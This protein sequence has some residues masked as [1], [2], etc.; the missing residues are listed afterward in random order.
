MRAR[1]GAVRAAIALTLMAALGFEFVRTAHLLGVSP[2][3]HLVDYTSYFTTMSNSLAAVT[4]GIGSVIAVRSDSD[5]EWYGQLVI[6]AVAY[7]MTTCTVY[8]ISLR[9]VSTAPD[10]WANE[11]LHVVGPL[12]IAL[13]W[14]VGQHRRVVPWR[15]IRNIMGVPVAWLGY[16]M[17]RGEAVGWYPYDFLDPAQSGGLVSV[18]GCVS[19]AT[20]L[21]IA[22]ALSAIAASRMRASRS[23]TVHRKGGEKLIGTRCALSAEHLATAG[24]VNQQRRRRVDA[25]GLSLRFVRNDI[26]LGRGHPRNEALNIGHGPPSRRAGRTKRRGI[27]HDLHAGLNVRRGARVPVRPLSR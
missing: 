10:S 20:A 23:V 6:A 1:E 19:V 24:R 8:N 17:L 4:F 16:T 22:F 21:I 14:V 5:P 26:P 18:A 9:A 7:T 25:V 11:V 2:L 15:S 12:S 3:D 27:Q 13:A